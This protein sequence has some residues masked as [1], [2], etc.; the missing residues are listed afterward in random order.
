M[1]G[2]SIRNKILQSDGVKRQLGNPTQVLDTP[3]G[4]AITI[5]LGLSVPLTK[6]FEGMT[7]E[8]LRIVQKSLEDE[9]HKKRG[10]TV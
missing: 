8:Q 9:I 2:Q 7:V 4:P 5:N 10:M 3:Q 1:S 6:L